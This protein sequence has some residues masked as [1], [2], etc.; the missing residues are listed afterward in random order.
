MFSRRVRYTGSRLVT[1]RVIMAEGLVR[2]VT[3]LGPGD[4]CSG[5]DAAR[6][7]WA[8]ARWPGREPAKGEGEGGGGGGG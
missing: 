1:V 7:G 2:V 3:Y 8:G 5:G 4:A 6:R